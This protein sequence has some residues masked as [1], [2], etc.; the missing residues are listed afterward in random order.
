MIG[1]SAERG[2]SSCGGLLCFGRR[3]SER[4]W[5]RWADWVDGCGKMVG[6]MMVRWLCWNGWTVFALVEVSRFWAVLGGACG[7]SRYGA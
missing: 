5:G 6:L 3:L 1:S 7:L 2:R 4:R